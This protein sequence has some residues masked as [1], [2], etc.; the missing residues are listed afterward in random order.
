MTLALIT[1]AGKFSANVAEGV[2]NELH[3]SVVKKPKYIQHRAFYI[4]KH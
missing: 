1:L 3:E 4:I 2:E